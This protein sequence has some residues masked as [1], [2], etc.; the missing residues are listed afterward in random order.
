MRQCIIKRV[1]EEASVEVK[2]VF[3]SD[4]GR[5]RWWFWL[6]G[7][8]SVLKLIDVVDFGDFWKMERRSPFLESAVV[9]V[10]GRH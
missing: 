9:R 10:L 6:E 8:E 1:P 3:K 7:E 4:D 5:V 2:R